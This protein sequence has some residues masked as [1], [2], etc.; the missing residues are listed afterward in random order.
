MKTAKL[1]RKKSTAAQLL[2]EENH[3]KAS[4]RS[5]RETNTTASNETQRPSKELENY[6]MLRRRILYGGDGGKPFY[7]D[8]DG[9]RRTVIYGAQADSIQSLPL[10]EYEKDP[11]RRERLEKLYAARLLKKQ[12]AASALE[13]AFNNPPLADDT[14]AD[15]V[16][17][18]EIDFTVVHGTPK[19]Y[20]VDA[21]AACNIC[22][23]STKDGKLTYDVAFVSTA[24]LP[25]IETKP[26]PVIGRD[27]LQV[28][29]PPAKHN[30]GKCTD[31]N[32]GE[33]RCK[34][35]KTLRANLKREREAEE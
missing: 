34:K 21:V 35:F 23:D 32:C 33:N 9:N 11:V 1:A 3:D 29:V 7:L 22:G 6:E 14:D 2:R 8:G 15:Y 17:N 31:E 10:H 13:E 27:K 4:R 25:F 12:A 19:T 26:L 5:A 24:P 30:C 20:G 28:D 16:P 18:R